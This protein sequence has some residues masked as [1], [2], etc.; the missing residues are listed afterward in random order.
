LPCYPP[1]ISELFKHTARGCEHV[2]AYYTRPLQLAISSLYRASGL[3][4]N[5]DKCSFELIIGMSA[6]LYRVGVAFGVTCTTAVGV[7]VAQ[8]WRPNS[9][10]QAA[11]DVTRFAQS[12]SL[13][14]S[15]AAQDVASGS[16]IVFGA[17]PFE[18]L[19]RDDTAFSSSILTFDPALH[20]Y[21]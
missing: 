21:D 6:L 19:M 3:H 12:S 1:L 2:S 18:F 20:D 10:T 14:A 15:R 16:R 11:T 7:S 17:Q 4:D 8:G 5:T 13:A 9:I